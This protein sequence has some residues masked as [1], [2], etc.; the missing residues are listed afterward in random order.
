MS[1]S[2]AE[3]LRRAAEKM[4]GY[5]NAATEGPWS[6][7]R[8]GLSVW[9]ESASGDLFVA[10]VGDQGNEF[11]EADGAFIAAMH[12]GVALLIADQWGSLAAEVGGLRYGQLSMSASLAV[13]GAELFLGEEVAADV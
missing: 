11:A 5:A 1:E 13:D 7:G 2:P 4:R 10:D 3:S 6:T 8:S 9:V 12:P